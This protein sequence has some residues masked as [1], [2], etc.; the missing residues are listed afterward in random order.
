[1]SSVPAGKRIWKCP[2]CGGEVLLSMTQ[3]D[4]MACETCLVKMKGNGR[5]RSDR[6]VA[7]A[8]AGSL[9]VWRALPDT[10]KLAIV[11]AAFVVGLLIGLVGGFVAGKATGAPSGTIVSEKEERP[12]SPGPGYKWVRGREHKDGSR[13]QGHWARDPYYKGEDSPSSKKK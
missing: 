2:D 13:G 3:L 7:E 1:M 9:G 12:E 4:P 8:S 5:L 11:A 6:G 10:A